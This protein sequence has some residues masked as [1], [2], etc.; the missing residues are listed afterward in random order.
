M[1]DV[2]HFGMGR[3]RLGRRT[4]LRSAV[5]AAAVAGLPAS[6]VAAT[7]LLRVDEA[8]GNEPCRRRGGRG[9]HR[10]A[11]RAAPASKQGGRV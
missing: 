7:T 8:Q 1:S 4:A 6:R 2:N 5:S 10:P 9:V 11:E 3:A